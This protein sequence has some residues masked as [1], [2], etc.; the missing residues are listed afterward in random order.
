MTGIGMFVVEYFENGETSFGTCTGTLINPRTVLF[1]AHCVNDL[2]AGALTSNLQAGWGFQT[3]ALPGL[4]HLVNNNY[5]TNTALAAY[6]V[7][8]IDWHPDSRLRPEAGGFLEADIA[9]ATLDTPAADVPTWV[10][11]FSPLPTPDEIDPETGTGYH[12]D[13]VG[14]GLTGNGTIGSFIDLDN[15]G[16]NDNQI[17]FRRRAAENM[18]AA[19]TSLDALDDAIFGQNSNLPALLYQLDFDDPDGTNPFDYNLLRDEALPREGLTAS[20]DS[21]GPLILDAA[22]NPG[23]SED[24]VI[25]TL[26]GGTRFFDDAP[27]SGYGS[28]SLYQPLFPYWDWIVENNPYR[29]AGAKA[30]SGDWEDP[31]HWQSLQDPNFR[32]IDTNGALVTGLPNRPG[33]G[34]NAAGP[35]FGQ[36]CIDVPPRDNP[37]GFTTC[38]DISPPGAEDG[39]LSATPLPDPTIDNGLPGATNFVPNNRAPDP[40]ANVAARYFDVTLSNVGR[41]TLSSEVEIDRLT[42]TKRAKLHVAQDGDLTSLMDITQSGYTSNVIVDGRL[43]TP[44]DYLLVSGWLFGSGTVEVDHLTNVAGVIAPG[45]VG[46]LGPL[47]IDG[48]L[49]LASRSIVAFQLDDELNGRLDVTGNI[50]LGGAL[51]VVGDTNYGNRHRVIDYG[52][53]VTGGFDQELILGHR[54]VL[55]VDVIDQDNSIY[56]EIGASSLADHLPNNVSTNQTRV[57]RA[58]D[59][60]REINYDALQSVYQPIDQMDGLTL[61]STFDQMV[62]RDAFLAGQTLRK[63]GGALDRRVRKRLRRSRR[64]KGGFLFSG[65]SDMLMQNSV[66]RQSHRNAG[67]EQMVSLS[68]LEDRTPSER[69][70]GFGGF[71]TISRFAPDSLAGFSATQIDMDGYS[72]TGGLDRELSNGA[73]IGAIASHSQSNGISDLGSDA[74]SLDGSTFGFYGTTPFLGASFVDAYFTVGQFGTR[75]DRTAILPDQIATSTG[76]STA[77][78]MTSNVTFGRAFAFEDGFS[79]TPQMQVYDATYAF[80]DYQETGSVFALDVDAR[81]IRTTQLKF[82]AAMDWTDLDL[83]GFY[84]SLSA[85]W[86]KDVNAKTDRIRTRFTAAPEATE[87][88]FDGAAPNRDWLELDARLAFQY[89][90][91]LSGSFGIS[92]TGNAQSQSETLL[93]GAVRLR[94]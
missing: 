12:V 47:T 78:M 44:G 9:L 82:G 90:E 35:G 43:A 27:V 2:P 75:A 31:D 38:A 63:M 46:S 87:I 6:G 58:L 48:S 14:Y 85:F 5:Q 42:V 80:D 86:V 59:A 54:G 26:S 88:L 4:S 25:G 65:S 81:E 94:F 93:G 76:Q 11:L 73:V 70:D 36:A 17:D 72:I 62:P 28:I 40:D 79:I 21:G 55:T 23:I 71:A 30:G 67:L 10:T 60:A 3:Y 8:Q 37:I 33:A 68:N 34:I 57:G 50:N 69:V 39:W 20:G 41:T 49:V 32:I 45:N 89:S 7:N 64:K 19:L 92:H 52:G 83:D 77:Q 18:L 16:E 91:A 84:P 74:S 51:V 61:A 66:S 15:D 22:G 1:A 29:Y 13:I 24:L 56:A 53:A